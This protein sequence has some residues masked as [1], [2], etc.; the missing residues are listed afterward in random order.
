MDVFENFYFKSNKTFIISIYPV[1]IEIFHY[2][3][4]KPCAYILVNIYGACYLMIL[5]F[6]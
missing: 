2:T 6:N 1:F 4:K 3:V 5:I